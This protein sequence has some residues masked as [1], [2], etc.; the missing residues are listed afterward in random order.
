MMIMN[1]ILYLLIIPIC[2]CFIF[3][4]NIKQFFSP[5][6]FTYISVDQYSKEQIYCISSFVTGERYDNLPTYLHTEM[7]TITEKDFLNRYQSPASNNLPF[8]I[9]VANKGEE[10]IGVIT[11]ECAPTVVANEE[12][13]LYPVLSNLIVRKDMRRKGVAKSLTRRAESI[14]RARRYKDVY[15][16][17]DVEN[18][19]ALQLYK[20]RGYK[21]TSDINETTKIACNNKRFVNIKCANMLMRKK[22]LF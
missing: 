12:K 17:V 1:M 13:K 8:I 20:S 14:V 11:I 7:V 21:V 18:K 16:Y 9:L 5:N 2:D 6:K 22:M 10:I 3:R 4:T 15:L 19:A